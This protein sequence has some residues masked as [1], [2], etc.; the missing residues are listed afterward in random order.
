MSELIDYKCDGCGG[1]NWHIAIAQRTDGKIFLLTMCANQECI[2]ARRRELDMDSSQ[3]II[4]DE[5]DITGQT[6]HHIDP[7]GIN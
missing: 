2:D 5:F 7:A 1:D 3:M 6:D 4:W